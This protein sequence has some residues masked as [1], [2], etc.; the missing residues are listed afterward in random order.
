MNDLCDPVLENI[1]KSGSISSCKALFFG[2][3]TIL[4]NMM[5]RTFSANVHSNVE[6]VHGF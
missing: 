6:Q 2:S 3:L 4:L 1:E 5:R